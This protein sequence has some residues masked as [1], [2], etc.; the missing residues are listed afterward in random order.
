[1]NAYQF[2]ENW[3]AFEISWDYKKS[4][5]IRNTG[6]ISEAYRQWSE[7]CDR[8]F[9]KLKENE[10][11]LNDIFIHMYG[12]E[13]IVD[14]SVKEENVTVRK[15]DLKREIKGLISYAVGCMFGRYSL[16]ED[17]LIYAGGEW[18][19]DRYKSYMVDQD[20]IIPICD[21]EY[22]ND[23]IVE[24][25]VDF[26]RTAYGD[27]TLDEN[28]RYIAKGLG[29]S[30][31]PKQ[32][33]RKYFNDSFYRDHCDMYQVPGSGKRPIYWLFDSGRKNG[34]KCLIYMHRYK[35][36]IIARIR[37]DYVHEQQSRYRTAISDL[38]Q[39]NSGVTSSE[40]VTIN[41]RLQALQDQAAEIREYE[42]KYI[43]LPIK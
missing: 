30:E 7:E 19:P 38:E 42:R 28:L 2:Q 12:F 22:F 10:E 27:E 4:P 14:S 24:R 31:N 26:I 34:F 35:A 13:S 9:S 3:D 37:T 1:M 20:N 41:K 17:G 11:H 43:I 6:L 15:A 32:V 29:G 18:N 36:D 16:D 39:R 33:I 25:F 40:R 21:D 5:L 8:R 23:D